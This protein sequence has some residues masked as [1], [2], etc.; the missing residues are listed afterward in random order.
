MAADAEEKTEPATPRRRNEA[1]NKGQVARSQDLNAVTVLLAGVLALK[2]LGPSIWA[3]MLATVKKGLTPLNM[4]SLDEVFVFATST[5]VEM[6]KHLA[7][8]VLIMAVALLAVLYAQ[9]GPLLTTHTLI[10]NLGKL[11][12]INGVKRLF[13]IR[14]VMLAVVNVLKLTVV[15]TVAYVTMKG[16]QA[17]V[18]Y[19][20]TLGISDIYRLGAKLIFELGIKLLAVLLIIALLDFAWQRRKHEKDLRMTKEEV[21]DEL[22][23]ME[24]DPMIKRRR[25]Q[26][27]LQMA[28]NRLKKDVPAADVIVTNPTHFA[29]AIKY[30]ADSMAAPKVVAKGADYV[31]LRIR[32]IAKDEGIPIVERR[33]LARGLFEAVEV[34]QYVPERFY[35]AI[36]EILAYVYELTGHT[37]PGARN[38][39][40]GA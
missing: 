21:K 30:D 4:S 12:P 18:L 27:Q 31:A 3:F 22:R 36:A 24:G 29:V 40:V 25:R 17:A 7:P 23:S 8:I 13:S 20:F 39:L 32:Q 1:R 2:F 33:A 35:Q 38:G 37:V 15:C 10:P 14:S 11:N 6:G 16:S 26:V 34:G 19:A 9:V 5:A 28:M